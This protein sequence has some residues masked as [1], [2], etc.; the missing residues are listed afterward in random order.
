MSSSLPAPKRLLVN[1]FNMNCVGHIHHGLWTHPRDRSTEYNTLGHWTDIARLL[2]RGLFDG[3][4]IAD[5]VGSYDVYQ[6]GLDLTLQEAIQ[7]PANDPWMLVS[8]MAAV[9]QHLGFGLTA[10]TSTETPFTFARK[11]STLDQLTQGRL[12]W[13]IV[14]GYI[15]SGARALGHER[16][17][18]H[19]LRYDQADDFLALCYRLWEGS[20]EDGAVRKDRARRIYADPA[21]VHAIAHDGPFHR[22]QGVHMCEPSPQRTPVLYQAGTSGRGQRFAGEH[23]ECVFIAANDP[24]AARATAGR[25]RQSLVAA[26]RRPE[27][28]KI[29]VALSVVAGATEAEARDRYAEYQRYANPEAGLA[30]F[31]AS[32][33]VDFARY[34]L[35]DP[36][37]YSGSNAIQSAG[38]TAQ[39]R[40][41]TTRRQLLQQFTL[42]SRYPTLVGNGS[43]I[44]DELVRW[45]DEGDID[46][47]NLSR[48]VVPE[49][50]ADFIDHVVP[51][52][53]ARGRYRTAYDEGTLRHKLFGQGDRL[54]AAHPA[55]AV[56]GAASPRAEAAHPVSVTSA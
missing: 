27:D 32:T 2:E 54:P 49:T 24:A 21:Q 13:N 3:L 40:G 14:T 38:Q 22:S 15:D 29:F 36:I 48:I 7:L 1:A 31:A 30:H 41:W 17:V 51:E 52:L 46:G 16:L 18:A 26:G 34:G 9:T 12:G 19:D 45:L 43:Q 6:G 5:I 50:W 39:Q 35:D 44:A 55:A 56:R 11:A 10:S 47:I 8:A 4:F 20:W 42:G 25:L 37:D 33:G 53:Q 23:A 28:V